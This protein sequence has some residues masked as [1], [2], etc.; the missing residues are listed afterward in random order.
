MK[1]GV[2]AHDYG[3][4][5]VEKLADILQREG[6]EAAQ[7][8]IPR[9]FVGVDSFADINEDLLYRMK[10]EFSARNIEIAVLS[11]YQDLGNPN[12][13]IRGAAVETFKKCL[14]YS[15]IVGARVVG[16]ETSYAHLSK[17]EKHIW[18][19]YMMDSLKRLTEEAEKQDVWMAIEPVAW[20]PLED[21]ETT[22]DV[23]HELGSDH[24]K[25]IFDMANVLE[26]PQ[27]IN[28]TAYWKKC[29]SL[30]GDYIETIHL[31]DFTVG[32]NNEYQPKLLGEGVMDYSVFKEWLKSRPDMPVMREE[33]NPKTAAK[34]LAF[35]RSLV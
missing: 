7:I 32:E 1:L 3:R 18:F 19:P 6:Y 23:L 24:V 34:D 31:K 4:H 10:N 28:Q 20:H 27:E 15:K 12:D 13:E 9:S 26:R 16:S 2:R 11:C 35:M 30:I 14:F 21:V 22:L 29:F 8:A 33:M 25:V 17:L 5:E